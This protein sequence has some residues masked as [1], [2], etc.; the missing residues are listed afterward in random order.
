MTFVTFIDFHV[1][2]MFY[3]LFHGNIKQYFKCFFFFFFYSFAC[4]LYIG[5]TFPAIINITQSF[6]NLD[7]LEI[8]NKMVLFNLVLYLLKLT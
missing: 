5:S 7:S 1:L 3:C 4:Y 8:L 2:L 6:R